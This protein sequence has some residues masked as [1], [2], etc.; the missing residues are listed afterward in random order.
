[1][2]K[3]KNIEKLKPRKFQRRF[4]VRKPTYYFLV[5]I[6]KNKLKN[7]NPQGRKTKLII[8]EQVLVTLQYFREYRTYFHIAEDWNVSESHKAGNAIFSSYS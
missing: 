4:G 6:V 2:L 5:E 7:K 3:L 1:V 8:E